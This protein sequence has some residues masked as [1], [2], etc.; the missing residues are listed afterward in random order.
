MERVADEWHG[1]V[2]ETR[3]ED[4]TF[5]AGGEGTSFRVD[6]L[7]DAGI[8]VD[9]KNLAVS[10]ALPSDIPDFLTIVELGYATTKPAFDGLA[11]GLVQ[12]LTS[13]GHKAS[14]GRERGDAQL[15][16][17]D[18]EA[19]GIPRNSVGRRRTRISI[20]R[21]TGS[22]MEILTTEAPAL[23]LISTPDSPGTQEPTL[24]TRRGKGRGRSAATRRQAETCD[25]APLRGSCRC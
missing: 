23:D 25:T 16:C 24:A 8:G 3:N 20:C 13:S 10:R 9:V 2:V 17:E 21:S 11:S 15:L 5:G 1:A 12:H 6:D 18:S 14:R 19:G 4:R 7:G 22:A